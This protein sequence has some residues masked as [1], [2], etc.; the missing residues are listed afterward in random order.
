MIKVVPLSLCLFLLGAVC[1]SAQTSPTDTAINEAVMRQAKT[2]VLHQKLVDAR[3]MADRHDVVDA[4]VLYQEAYDLT[5]QIG[6]GVKTE[7]AQAVAGVV[8]TRMELAKE[9]RNNSDYI[10]ANK[11]LAQALKVAPENSSVLALKAQLAHE[12]E[13]MAGRVPSPAVQ[14]QIPVVKRDRVAAA[15]LVQDAK[16]FYE[17]GKLDES[18]AKLKAALAI[19][20]DNQAAYFYQNLVKQARIKRESASHEADTKSRMGQV[21]KSWVLPNGTGTVLP[22][23][24]TLPSFANPYVLTNSLVHTGPG[25]MVIM[26]KLARI[27]LDSVSY[28]GVPLSEVL[29]DLT[30]K[31]QLRDPEKK[32]INFL[33][34]PNADNSG[35]DLPYTGG[36]GGAGGGQGFG[37]GFGGGLP[38][39]GFGGGAAATPAPVDPTTG[40]PVA[41]A[42]AAPE[43]NGDI[44]QDALIKLNLA[45]V[46]LGD[47]LEAVQ[48]VSTKPIKYS[49]R[50]YGI[51]FQARDT[52]AE[53]PTLVTRMFKV[54]PNTFYS[55]LESVSAES[56]VGNSSTTGGG[57]GGGGGSSGGGGGGGSGNN[58]SGMSGVVGV[59][60]AVPG[61]G[62]A[63]TT[64]GGGQ[65]G[66][67]GGGGGQ[68]AQ[69]AAGQ[70]PLDSGGIPAGGGGANGR[71]GGQANGGGGLR[72]ITRVTL[73][74]EVSIA[75]RNFFAALGVTLRY[76]GG[77][78]GN[79]FFNDRLG[80]LVVRGT[81]QDLDL[82]EQALQALNQLPPQVHIKTRFIQVQENN[83]N[84]LGFQWYLGNYVNGSVVAS[85]GTQGSLINQSGNAFPSVGGAGTAQATTDQSLTQGLSNPLNAP[86]LTT[87][88]GILTD[89]NFRLAIQ[90]LQQR[91]GVETLAEPEGTTISG[92]QMQMKATTLLQIVT[93]FNFQQGT[94]ATTTGGTGAGV[95]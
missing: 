36:V 16:L 95:P 72:N 94:S 12:T 61:A 77:V 35:L 3:R 89:P 53:P 82:I 14:E 57:G 63:R 79:L 41:A 11:E 60:D 59:V 52:R 33:I 90:A 13:M 87:I 22:S 2:I 48:M 88:T 6:P 18:E 26:D 62:S 8:A 37:G 29:R 67:G 43:N 75:A 1:V 38:G 46:T 27:H 64:T 68:G 15:T 78:E 84:A 91:Q 32:G 93:G 39:G 5:Q 86:T 44:A 47:V 71:G 7:T 19:D 65:G 40:L 49:I 28:D 54:D 10:N 85:G 66:G 34:N 24:V 30:V 70:N 9:A 69:G 42:P 4:A 74:A 31:T 50:D 80:L 17:M 25:R 45:D 83:Q 56:F 20:P 92:R 81:E 76:P 55:G 58:N 21:E 73:T 51:V 23:N